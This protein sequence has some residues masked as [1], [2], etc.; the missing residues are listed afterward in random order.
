MRIIGIDPGL[1]HTGW[2]IID[3]NGN[4]LTHVANGTIST[5]PKQDIALRLKKISEG[6]KEQIE[7]HN[8]QDAAI[9]EVFVNNNP[10]SSLKLGE[11]RGAAIVTLAQMHLDVAQYTPNMVKKSVVGAGHAQKE[12]VQAMIKILLP[13][14]EA[15]P[16]AADALAVAICHAHHG[17]F[18]SHITINQQ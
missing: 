5:N 6:I 3:L 16:D 8:P 9:E 18:N 7:I 17:N 4:S 15:A 1:Q 10:K 12:Q 14:V 2:G 13:G 11:A